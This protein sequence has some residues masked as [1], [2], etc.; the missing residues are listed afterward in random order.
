MAMKLTRKVKRKQALAEQQYPSWQWTF[1]KAPTSLLFVGNGGI[2]NGLSHKLILA[3]L[4]EEPRHVYLPIECDFAI[5]EFSD[6]RQCERVLIS[7]NGCCVQEEAEKRGARHLV[8]HLLSCPPLHLFLSYLATLPSPAVIEQNLIRGCSSGD[9]LPPGC[10]L[11]CDFVSKDEETKLIDCFGFQINPTEP[12][13]NLDSTST[14]QET[15]GN[16]IFSV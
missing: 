8:T 5:L 1:H 2:K 13:S 11:L 10:H 7:L 14:F 4:S 15:S 3:L 6:S 9:L 12:G 16:V